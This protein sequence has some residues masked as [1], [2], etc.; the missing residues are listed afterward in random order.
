MF[1]WEEELRA[2]VS[3]ANREMIGKTIANTTW[4]HPYDTIRFHMTDGSVYA[5]R[6]NTATGEIDTYRRS[7]PPRKG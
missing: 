6:A 4:L 3:V 2:M 1:D 7:E 5:I